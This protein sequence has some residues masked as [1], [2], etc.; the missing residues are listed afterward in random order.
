VSIPSCPWCGHHDRA[1]EVAD[2][3]GRFF[4]ACGSL[5]WG[6]DSEWRRL[7]QHR[8]QAIERRVNTD[9]TYEEAS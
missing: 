2:P 6:T 3:N 1:V 5:F 8:R 9:H 4:C 7:A